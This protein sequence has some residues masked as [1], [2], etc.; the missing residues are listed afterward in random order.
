MA[1][2]INSL[3]CADD[4]AG[5]THEFTHRYQRR[6]ETMSRSGRGG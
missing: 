5:G 6:A 1:A 3:V 2:S 4:N